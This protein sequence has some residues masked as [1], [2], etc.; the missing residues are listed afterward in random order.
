MSLL[1]NTDWLGATDGDTISS[2]TP[3]LGPVPVSDGGTDLVVI[4]P[5]GF[6]RCNGGG[7]GTDNS[8]ILCTQTQD[9]MEIAFQ[10]KCR[11]NLSQDTLIV[12]Y[13]TSGGTRY[14]AGIHWSSSAA[15]TMGFGGGVAFTTTMEPIID[16]VYQC[17]LRMT[18]YNTQLFVDGE[19]M[20]TDEGSD[21]LGLTGGGPFTA[22]F[23][24]GGT[25]TDTNE[26]HG[27]QLG[28]ILVYS[29]NP[30]PTKRNI[31]SGLQTSLQGEVICLCMCVKIT[32]G[33]GVI[34]GFTTH[35][36]DVVV[37]GVTYEALSSAQTSNIRTEVGGTAD[38][39]DTVGIL[40]SDRITETD[41]RAGV[42]DNAN[43]LIFL[44][45]WSDVSLGKII[46][47]RGNI[48]DITLVD[49]QYT[50]SMRSLMQR[51]QQ[52]IGELTSPTCRVFDL[53]DQR[54]KFDLTGNTLDGN[55]AVSPVTIDTVDDQLTLHIDGGVGTPGYY[56]SGKLVGTSGVNMGYAREIK[57]HSPG[58]NLD[59]ITKGTGTFFVLPTPMFIHYRDPLNFS[60]DN[61]T[62]VNVPAGVWTSIKLRVDTTWVL[63]ASNNF[64][65]DQYTIQIPIGAAF[66]TV[67]RSAGAP[68]TY[69]D[70]I[71]LGQE[72]IA[73]INS[74]VTPTTS[75]PLTFGIR[76][77]APSPGGAPYF[78]MNAVY[79][80]MTFEG[81]AGAG[82]NTVD[83]IVLFEKFPFPVV[84][85]DTFNAIAGCNRTA[86]QCTQKFGNIVNFRGEPN[87]PGTDVL[88]KIGRSP[89]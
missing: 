31:P 59:V 77:T 11:S 14:V 36:E 85:G 50:A 80:S 83:R 49:G 45:D 60:V 38:N 2:Y 58:N 19:L 53:G 62:I 32:R 39:V 72:A 84:A 61:V 69:S 81:I 46:Q 25:G 9:M 35:D 28:K 8:Y 44:C 51:F 88:I 21:A 6:V 67:V 87:I 30:R 79:I 63:R 29:T 66:D 24:M 15:W 37:D 27:W 26:A 13:K 17:R 34:L 43:V 5:D 56:S 4:A 22:G 75:V 33:D 89:Q 68:G 57:F 65:T 74:L 86:F 71:Q 16:H 1:S 7:S 82:S 40:T 78:N 52:Q 41:M 10:I 48:G 55:T 70:E 20:G 54:C 3:N 23:S 47:M 73:Y 18:P 64:G 42:Y 76:H 12:M